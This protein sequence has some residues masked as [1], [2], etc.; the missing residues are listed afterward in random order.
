MSIQIVKERIRMLSSGLVRIPIAT[1]AERR[2]AYAHPGTD[3]RRVKFERGRYRFDFVAEKGARVSQLVKRH[4]AVLGFNFPFFDKDAQLPI[5][6]VWTGGKYINGAYGEMQYWHDI[7]F[8][9]GA[10][11]ISLFTDGQRRQFDF[12]VQGKILVLGGKFVGKNDGQSCQRTFAW[13][14]AVGDFHVAFA[15]GRTGSDTGL[16]VQEMGAYALLHGAVT[17]IEGDGGGSTIL[18]DQSG[19]L[20][21]KLNTGANERHV[22]HA[23]LVFERENSAGFKDSDVM[24]YGDLKKLGLVK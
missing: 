7:G 17:A 24:T 1:E 11:E 12:S 20:N 15:D 2:V 23:V 18:A 16:T 4:G 22:H 10:A 8:R 19:G 6:N 9:D 13:L 21:Q 14:D 3:V 5:G